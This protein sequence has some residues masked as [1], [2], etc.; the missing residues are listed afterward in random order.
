MSSAAARQM[1]LEAVFEAL[2]T[3]AQ[4]DVREWL[5]ELLRGGAGRRAG[6]AAARA[7]PGDSLRTG[8]KLRGLSTALGIY[9]NGA[10][11]KGAGGRE[12]DVRHLGAFIPA[13]PNAWQDSPPPPL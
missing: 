6:V 13:L 7:S 12:F 5:L 9:S 1:D 3:E 10:L 11:V 8:A 4:V 2:P